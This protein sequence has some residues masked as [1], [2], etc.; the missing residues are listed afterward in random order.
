MV[1]DNPTYA[2]STTAKVYVGHSTVFFGMRVETP[3]RIGGAALGRPDH[4][5]DR[6][7]RSPFSVGRST[8]LL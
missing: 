2:P 8:Q 5:C 4:L 3:S 1:M 7:P 6:R